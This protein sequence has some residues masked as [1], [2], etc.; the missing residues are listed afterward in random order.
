MTDCSLY[1]LKYIPGPN[2]GWIGRGNEG[3]YVPVNPNST[4]HLLCATPFSLVEKLWKQIR[5]TEQVSQTQQRVTNGNEA[6]TEEP[7]RLLFVGDS[8]VMGIG[9]EAQ[10][11]LERGNELPQACARILSERLGRDVVWQSVGYNGATAKDV[12]DILGPQIT[13]AVTIL[14]EDLEKKEE[15]TKLKVDLVVLMCGLND[16][17]D[18]VFFRGN[19]WEFRKELSTTIKYIHSLVSC[20]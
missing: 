7:F 1:R 10:D 12:R 4:E 6:G 9:I 18:L 3:L 20:N 5:E 19:P 16:A 2:C 15:A 13:D 17:K 14:H 8:M 11:L